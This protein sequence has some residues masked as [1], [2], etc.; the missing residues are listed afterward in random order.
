VSGAGPLRGV[1]LMSQR[2]GSGS[3]ASGP[4][5]EPPKV[6]NVSKAFEFLTLTM[7]LYHFILR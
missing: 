3:A 1:T 4:P 6:N 5:P 2:R 7:I